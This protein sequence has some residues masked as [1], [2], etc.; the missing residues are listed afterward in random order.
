VDLGDC[1]LCTSARG[2]PVRARLEV[3]L[4]DRLQ[5]GLEAG[6]DHP[7]GHGRYPQRPQLAAGL[8]DHH[9]PY[10]NRPELPTLERIAE[11]AQERLHPDPRLDTGH[12]GPVDSRSPRSC[13]RGHPFPRVYQESRIM[14]EIEQVIEP[15]GGL[16]S[17]PTMQFGLHP[18]YREVGRIGIRPLHGVGI[19]RRIFGHYIP[20]LS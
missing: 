19:H 2:E 1:V 18:P 7:V 5:H 16:L 17:R 11:L 4:E 9:L 6:L 12:R 3:G 10:L 15:A 13:V 14:N 20:S 8:R